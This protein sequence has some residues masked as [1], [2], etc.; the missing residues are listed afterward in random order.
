MIWRNIRCNCILG[1]RPADRPEEEHS[2]RPRIELLLPIV[3]L[4]GTAQTR[5]PS[6]AALNVDPT[7]HEWDPIHVGMRSQRGG[8]DAYGAGATRVDQAFRT[9]APL[10][11]GLV[12]ENLT[13][14]VT[15]ANQADFQMVWAGCKW[16]KWIR[17]FGMPPDSARHC[18]AD[19]VFEP[20]DYGVRTATLEISDDRGNRATSALKGKGMFGCN[21]WQ[22]DVCSYAHHYSGTAE[23]KEDLTAPEAYDRYSMTVTVR[24]GVVNCQGSARGKG[25]D[26]EVSSADLSGPGIITIDFEDMRGD[27]SFVDSTETEYAQQNSAALRAGLPFAY[28]V[29]IDCPTDEVDGVDLP[30]RRNGRFQ[31]WPRGYAKAPGDS[32][33]GT[34]NQ[35]AP[36]ADA[37]NGVDGTIQRTWTLKSN[38]PPRP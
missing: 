26:T 24:K 37:L 15:G 11:G 33:S 5:S 13:F 38:R 20:Q 2:V 29:M 16:D 7:S 22:Y 6:P 30:A 19:V 23:W 25:K 21:P 35:R 28:N 34:Q 8:F 10:T 12:S 27:P 17:S 4:V 3:I 14:Q 36:E 32:L 9:N 18:Y 31:L 1:A